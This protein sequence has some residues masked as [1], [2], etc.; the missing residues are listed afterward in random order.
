MGFDGF[1]VPEFAK[2]YIGWVVGMDWPEGDESGCFRLADAC[3][4]AAHRLVEGTAAD[5]PGS[6]SKIGSAWD[7]EAHLAFAAH[8][9]AVVGGQLAAVV[10]R[11]VDTAVALNGVGVQIQYAKYMIEA[12]VWLLI[13]Q[14]A[15]LLAMA[16][17]S[18]GASLALIPPRLQLARMTVAQIAKT[19][20][21]NIALFAG[22]VAGMDLGI[23]ILQM[24]KGRRDEIDVQQVAISAAAGGAMGGLMGLLSGGLSRLATPALRA[25]LTRAEMSTAEKLL[26]AA[27]SSLYGQAAQFAVTGGITTAGT[28]LAQGHFSWDMLAKGIT[29]SALGADGQH[30]ATPM[31]HGAD[32]SPT[33]GPAAPSGDPPPSGNPP[34]SGR[35]PSGP[36][37][38]GA[39]VPETNGE[40]TLSAAANHNQRTTI[41]AGADG[42]SVWKSLDV[43]SQQAEVAAAR[44]DGP[45]VWKSAEALTRPD[46]SPAVRNSA[47]PAQSVDGAAARPDGPPTWKP[48]EALIQSAKG[49]MHNAQVLLAARPEAGSHSADRGVSEMSADP[50]RTARPE[51]TIESKGAEPTSRPDTASQSVN[52]KNPDTVASAATPSRPDGP[53]AWKDKPDILPPPERHPPRTVEIGALGETAVHDVKVPESA[54]AAARALTDGITGVTPRERR[55]IREWLAETLS[56]GNRDTWTN[57]LQRGVALSVGDKVIYLKLT[58]SEFTHMEHPSLAPEKPVAFGGDGVE[59]KSS[60]AS[61]LERTAGMIRALNHSSDEAEASA[62]PRAGISNTLRTTHTN[63]IEVIS[64]HKAVS[65]AH[66]YFVADISLE[67]YRNGEKVTETAAVPELS[68]TLPFPKQ[69]TREGPLLAA[70]HPPALPRHEV[71]PGAE[72]KFRDHGIAITGMDVT[73]LVLEV[74]RRTLS[75]GVPAG[76][77]VKIVE[78][79]TSTVLSEQGMKNRSQSL[80]SSG[81][82]S[83]A[84]RYKSSALRSAEDSIEVTSRITRIEPIDGSGRPPIE[85][86]FRDDM[87]RRE[88]EGTTHRQGAS[89]NVHAGGKIGLTLGD[90]AEVIGRAIG[91]FGFGSDHVTTTNRAH[92]NHTVLT[93]LD[94]V[95]MYDAHM[96]LQVETEK[97]GTFEVEVKAE[98]TVPARDA[99]RMEQDIFGHDLRP[100]GEFNEIRQKLADLH[101]EID[102]VREEFV[103]SEPVGEYPARGEHPNRGYDPH[104]LEP[105]TLAAGRGTGLGSGI[106]VHSETLL[107]TEIRQAVDQ[108]LPDL[109]PGIRRQVAR[110]IESRFGGVALEADL[111]HALHGIRYD[112]TIGGYTFE[113]LA[114]GTL[115]RRHQ[116]GST[117]MTVNERRITSRI[118]TSQ[119]ET[120]VGGRAE[121]RAVAR[122][123][124]N[125]GLKIDPANLAVTRSGTKAES[126]G[127]SAGHTR[128]DRTETSGG[129]TIT[130]DL[131]FDVRMRVSRNGTEVTNTSWE[132]HGSKAEILLPNTHLPETPVLAQDVAHV[133]RI[134]SSTRPPGYVWAHDDRLHATVRLG[135]MPDLAQTVARAHADWAG[136]PLP[137]ERLDV[138]TVFE[139]ATDV[140]KLET[141]I[142]SH[143]D[144]LHYT[145]SDQGGWR[146]DVHVKADVAGLKHVKSE[147]GVEHEIYSNSNSKMT[148]SERSRQALGGHA[149]TGLRVTFGRDGEHGGE[150]AGH[151][152]G[153]E[154]TTGN[155]RKVVARAGV[156]AAAKSMTQE[157]SY[158]G[159]SDVARVTY[160]DGSPSHWYR[161]DLVLEVTPSRTNGETVERGPTTYVR[162]GE[163]MDLVLPDEVARRHGLEGPE[164]VEPAKQAG[165]T[166]RAYSA[167]EAAMSTASVQHLDAQTVLPKILEKLRDE[168]LFFPDQEFTNHPVA[169]HLRGHY[170]QD[171]LATK[172]GELR[173]NGVSSWLFV[174]DE[175]GRVTE[176]VG[177]RV[178]AEI[179]D[180]VHVGERSDTGLM[181]RSER[182][183]GDLS[184]RERGSDHGGE[185]LARYSESS[186]GQLRGAEAG[187]AN[188]RDSHTV[189]A[190]GTN[191]KDI[192]RYQTREAPQ[193]FKHPV[194]YEI[195]LE[196]AQVR[197]VLEPMQSA[198]RSML[199][200]VGEVTGRDGAVRLFD[201]HVGVTSTSR[202]VADGELGVLV[203]GHLTMEVPQGT[204]VT[205]RTPVAAADP[206]W[207]EPAGPSTMTTT[208]GRGVPKGDVSQV[209]FPAATM[210][211]QWAPVAAVPPKLR[212]EVPSLDNR[213]NGFEL[214]RPAGM[215]LAEAAKERTMRAHIE[216]L[217]AH[218]YEIPGVGKVG[219]DVNGA[220]EITSALV[221]QRVYAQTMS[222][223]G[224]GQEQGRGRA[225]RAGGS[226]GSTGEG[227]LGFGGIGGSTK[228]ADEAASRSAD[229]VERNFLEKQHEN[230]YLEVDISVVLYGEGRPLV[231]DVDKG[232]YLRL[233]PEGLAE[234]DAAH[235][236]VIRR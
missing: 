173:G 100:R 216:Q 65:P 113:I 43:P 23:Q 205:A 151:T 41:N 86:M 3:V 111:T 67:V 97:L 200:K 1:L 112:K 115:G 163:I 13:A 104:A 27:S 122:L 12:T 225:A 49:A 39:R 235:P 66:D 171:A 176:R 11:L 182:L 191:A 75:A 146:H 159:G 170:G 9:E 25:G 210:V 117:D 154:E 215:S 179:G 189:D 211:E 58:P 141:M 193:E 56:D 199:L 45:P 7:G 175:H 161:G 6:A 156:H 208:L 206:R 37:T 158:L 84:V 222:T 219:I 196:R 47:L 207:A 69:F 209:A 17:A 160:S 91:G 36:D 233:T 148:D 229:I 119:R 184:V 201:R 164:G 220:R 121:V 57:H 32:G 129:F 76:E 19:C 203:P 109:P 150:T 198:A 14:L 81:A 190:R 127:F 167:P 188:F 79:L 82:G 172:L 130:R 34:S 137:A 118:D 61:S 181:L 126:V 30:L 101:R 180:G 139:T 108:A 94:D 62:L 144:G 135:A 77:V 116:V 28:L 103:R 202:A 102:N 223:T 40:T 78:H 90:R 107:S 217:L 83:E 74:Q 60:Q 204:P 165:D 4:T 42:P 140:I 128:Y 230:T 224:H 2:P 106:R 221:K 92:G 16:L 64:G 138:P 89:L 185:L 50:S 149:R 53:V 99:P 187:Y 51:G 177:I 70:D 96:R 227:N 98:L 88:S 63:G 124:V 48:R 192:N 197:P 110:D 15:Y 24:A 59:G 166:T 132:V 95:T 80:L 8:V 183:S 155:E 18:G 26:A 157:S 31:P 33:P 153:D 214:S 46:G 134:E 168:K 22:I 147:T 87:G 133:G 226:D 35:P 228:T 152:R 72:H 178:T 186:D 73:P 38:G 20:L 169:E 114:E 85:T 93:R 213:P 218:D 5:Q 231:I 123:E 120:S 142:T 236:G 212:E 162:V 54:T 55:A 105:E 174:T 232:L 29:S 68:V 145:V 136:L 71:P 234:F 21:R 44:P 195:T 143:P 131:S 10:K 125:E 194:T 52:S